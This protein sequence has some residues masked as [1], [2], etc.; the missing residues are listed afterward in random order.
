MKQMSSDGEIKKSRPKYWLLLGSF[1]S[2]SNILEK[3]LTL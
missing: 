3:A 1:G 2:Q